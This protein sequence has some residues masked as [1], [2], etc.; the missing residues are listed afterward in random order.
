MPRVTCLNRKECLGLAMLM[1]GYRFHQLSQL[2][3]S[4]LRFPMDEF[5]FECQVANMTAATVLFLFALGTW[6]Y[7][8]NYSYIRLHVR[9]FSIVIFWNVRHLVIEKCIKF[10]KA[11]ETVPQDV[12]KKSE[13]RLRKAYDTWELAIYEEQ[14]IVDI[15]R[16]E[17]VSLTLADVWLVLIKF[18]TLWVVFELAIEPCLIIGFHKLKAN[19]KRRFP[20]K[21]SRLSV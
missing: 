7:Q 18:L 5:I 20:R 6:L 3:G 16:C 2:C 21:S 17:K 13:L 8:S 15:A 9:I 4:I 1:I 19:L 10:G 12:V 11:Y 14:Q